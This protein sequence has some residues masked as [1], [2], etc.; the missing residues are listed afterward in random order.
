MKLRALALLIGL[1]ATSAIASGQTPATIEKTEISGISEDNLSAALRGDLQKL[2]G[3]SYDEKAATQIAER[4]HA[5]LP[6]YVVTSTTAAGTQTGRVVLVFAVA[7]NIN[8]KYIVES[9]DLKGTEKSKL[10]EGLWAEMQKMVGHPVDDA[11]ADQFRERMETELKTQHIRRSVARGSDPQHVRILYDV[12]GKNSVGFGGGGG[13]H[14]RQKFSGIANATYT[15][16]DFAG[17]KV[18]GVNDSSDLLERYAGFRYGAWGLYKR[19]RFNAEY[20][21]FRA[22]W[23]PGT[24]QAA[25][26]SGTSADLYRLRDTIEPSAK[27]TVSPGF[28]ITLGITASQ[29]QMLEPASHFESVRTANGNADYKFYLTSS[30]K[31]ELSGSYDIRV[32]GD[33]LGGSASFTR[34]LFDQNYEWNLKKPAPG[35]QFTP[36]GHRIEVNVQLGRITGIAPMFERFSLGSPHTLTG[37]NKYDISPLGAS[38]MAYGSVTYTNRYVS[39]SFESGSVW[40]DGQPKTLHNSI[41]LGLFLGNILHAPKPL[42]ILLNAATPG[43]GIPLRKNGVHPIYTIGGGS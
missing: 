21:S 10:S 24:L 1:I 3:Q 41:G 18:S 28:H 14:S 30:E 19:V 13:Y 15:F 29:L 37:W 39:T 5:E 27:I 33:T 12:P 36:D 4:I 23:S 25:S 11:A 2:V 31:H 38:R 22:Q 20:S 9:V 8:A 26:A 16:Y 32:A 17:V 42:R 6:D 34:H 7:H 35:T 40:N 43:I